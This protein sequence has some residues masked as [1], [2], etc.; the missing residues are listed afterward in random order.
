MA[1][2]KISDEEVWLILACYQAGLSDQY[3]SSYTA[4][5]NWENFLAEIVQK[6]ECLENQFQ[7]N[8]EINLFQIWQSK[9]DFKNL[10]T[11]LETT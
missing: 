7:I 2:V 10:N 8:F 4:Y 6:K 3:P 5:V 9:Q 11:L 1:A